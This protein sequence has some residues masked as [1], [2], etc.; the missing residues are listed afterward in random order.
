MLIFTLILI[1]THS[2]ASC[3]ILYLKY[4]GKYSL[5]RVFIL[6]QC[7][8]KMCHLPDSNVECDGVVMQ[9][10]LAG[11]PAVC[12]LDHHHLVQLLNQDPHVHPVDSYVWKTK[13]LPPS[14]VKMM[15]VGRQITVAKSKSITKSSMQKFK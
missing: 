7:N 14:I 10:C 11:V 2:S 6:R 9:R 12:R 5:L 3:V 4:C 13:T 15:A 8:G 1:F